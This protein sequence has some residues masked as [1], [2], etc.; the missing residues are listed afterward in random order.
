MIGKTKRY[1]ASF[2][3]RETTT[4]PLEKTPVAGRSSRAGMAQ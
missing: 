3:Q 2:K 1:W 4:I